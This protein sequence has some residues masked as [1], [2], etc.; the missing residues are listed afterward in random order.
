MKR[1]GT[2]VAYQGMTTVPQEKT[3]AHPGAILQHDFLKPRG[4]DVEA[5]SAASGVSI[6]RLH[7]LMGG[8]C[9][10]EWQ[11]AWLLAR[12]LGTSPEL[13]LN[14]QAAHDLAPDRSA[15]T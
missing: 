6:E 14:L 8:G 2:N 9:R 4:L 12:A 15:R 5:F 1:G 3:A 11:T 10:V 13:W 7:R